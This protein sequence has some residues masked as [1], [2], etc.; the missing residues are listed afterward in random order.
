MTTSPQPADRSIVSPEDRGDLDLLTELA[1]QPCSEV[2]TQTATDLLVGDPTTDLHVGDVQ[3]VREVDAVYAAGDTFARPD[4]AA[5]G[6]PGR[7][8]TVVSLV[9]VGLCAGVDVLLTGEIT[10]FFD[11]CFVVVCLVSTMAVRRRDLF[12]TGVLP[13]LLFAVVVAS[14]AFVDPEVFV[15]VGGAFKA[16]M[17][18]LAQ[19]ASGLIT[20][21]AVGLLT[22][23][24]RVGAQRSG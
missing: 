24:C 17:S 2:E 22:V 16:F 21:Y 5:A 11:L 13:P 9:A 23:G 7:G 20:G 15:Q 19:H 3:A 1:R 12:T 10:M 6:M 18:G 4:T 14:V 8:V